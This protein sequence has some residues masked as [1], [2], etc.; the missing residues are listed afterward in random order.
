MSRGTI[1]IVENEPFIALELDDGFRDSGYTPICVPSV[2]VAVSWLRQ[3]RPTAAIVNFEDDNPSG[4]VL[5]DDLSSKGVLTVVYTGV[6]I[7]DDFT[8]RLPSSLIWISK[9]AAFHEILNAVEQAS[10]QYALA[11]Q[12]GPDD[13]AGP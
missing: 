1:L 4:Q 11:S 8:A 5:F 3:N 10:D 2:A 6:P 7:E 13:L 9:P 12:G